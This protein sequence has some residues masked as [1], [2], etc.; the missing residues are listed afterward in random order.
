M[1]TTM[2]T[3]M[4]FDNE[5]DGYNDDS[6]DDDDDENADN[7][8]DDGRST[9]PISGKGRNSIKSPQMHQGSK[10]PDFPAPNHS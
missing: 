8:D 1:L 3:M 5:E 10:H 6:D 2:T 7:D 4:F 9:H